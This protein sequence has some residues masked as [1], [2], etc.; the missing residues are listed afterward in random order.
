MEKIQDL[1][2]EIESIQKTQMKVQLEV[3]NLGTWVEKS[4]ATLTIKIQEVEE[5]ISG[6]E[7]KIEDMDNCQ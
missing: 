3:R 4:E 2:V 5:R 1:Q 7:D 6:T